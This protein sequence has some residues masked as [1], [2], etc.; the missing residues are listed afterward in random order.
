MMMSTCGKVLPSQ[1]AWFKT[2]DA[3]SRYFVTVMSWWLGLPEVLSACEMS[4][5]ICIATP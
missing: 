3:A 2:G 5:V 1:H 4:P